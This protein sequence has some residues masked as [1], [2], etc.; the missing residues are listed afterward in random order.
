M[1]LFF[2]KVI[3]QQ[4]NIFYCL[5]V[6]YPFTLSHLADTFIQSDLQMRTMELEA[7]KINKKRNDMQVL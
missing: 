1:H 4:K 5:F 7:I 6:N 3:L 2:K